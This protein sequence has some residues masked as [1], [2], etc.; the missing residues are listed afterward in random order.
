MQIVQQ[1]ANEEGRA[2]P[3]RL[4]AAGLGAHIFVLLDACAAVAVSIAALDWIN[5]GLP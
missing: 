4:L 2:V 1:A 3:R 5:D